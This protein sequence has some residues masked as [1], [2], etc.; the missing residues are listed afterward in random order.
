MIEPGTNV[1]IMAADALGAP[2][3]QTTL[4]SF[5]NSGKRAN[6]TTGI[7]RMKEILHATR[8]MKARI[9]KIFFKKAPETFKET[10]Y[11]RKKLVDI[12]INDL[13]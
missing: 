10:L 9:G 7:D 3:T 6:T 12:R 11:Y 1:G 13:K 5:H 8:N 2:L 4:N